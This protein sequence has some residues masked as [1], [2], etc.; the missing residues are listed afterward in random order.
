M[1]ESYT[2]TV[3]YPEWK[4]EIVIC[5]NCSSRMRFTPPSNQVCYNCGLALNYEDSYYGEYFA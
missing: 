5:P 3:F 2:E 1:P 4:V